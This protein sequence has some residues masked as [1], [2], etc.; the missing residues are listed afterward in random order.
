M[1][2]FWR[3]RILFVVVLFSILSLAFVVPASHENVSASEPLSC[4]L[5]LELPELATTQ[6]VTIDHSVPHISTD[7]PNAGHPQCPSARERLGRG[8]PAGNPRKPGP[9][10]QGLSVPG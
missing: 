4:P 6:V 10:I 3:Q 5:P 2:M 7:P 1:D 9:L 8:G